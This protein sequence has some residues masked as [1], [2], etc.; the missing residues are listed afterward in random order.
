MQRSPPLRKQPSCTSGRKCLIENRFS[1]I[2][3][4]YDAEILA[5][6]CRCSLNCGDFSLHITTSGLKSDATFEFSAPVFPW[7]RGHF[8][9]NIGLHIAYTER[10]A[11]TL[12]ILSVQCHQCIALDRQYRVVG[13][14]LSSIHS[15]CILFR[16]YRASIYARAVLGVVILPACPSVI[17]VGCDKTKWCTADILILYERAISLLLWHQQWLVGDAP[18]RLKSALKVTHPLRKMPTVTDFRI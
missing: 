14:L 8:E 13:W 16:F 12:V 10:H 1:D 9:R 7:R 5:I 18:F 15:C 11:C 2:D 17:R 6:R 3:L 4:I